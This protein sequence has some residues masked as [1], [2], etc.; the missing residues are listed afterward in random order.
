MVRVR[1]R[2]RACACVCQRVPACASVCQRACSRV[3]AGFGLCDGVFLAL[4]AMIE[5]NE[6]LTTPRFKG[7]RRFK[8]KLILCVPCPHPPTSRRALRRP[9]SA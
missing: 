2:V 7:A 1:V 6:G 4:G 5:N 9:L 3:W 8:S